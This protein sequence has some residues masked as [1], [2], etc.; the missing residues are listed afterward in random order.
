MSDKN[1]DF[2]DGVNVQG[3]FDFDFDIEEDPSVA[4]DDRS[5]ISKGVG[6]LSEGVVSFLDE[7]GQLQKTIVSGM[8]EAAAVGIGELT[9][10]YSSAT[11]EINEVVRSVKPGLTNIAT[12]IN[13]VLPEGKLKSAVS[14]I[15]RK[16]G[17][18][19]PNRNNSNPVK[20]EQGR[21]MKDTLESIFKVQEKDKTENIVRS[22]VDKKIDRTMSVN[23]HQE[24][25][26]ILD[27]I[28]TSVTGLATYN[29]TI[30]QGYQK[31]SLEL[32]F[33]S[34]FLLKEMVSLTKQ[35]G[36][37]GKSSLDAI[38]KNTGLPDFLKL[39]GPEMMSEHWVRS[40]ID[41]LGQAIYGEGSLL[42]RKMANIK[43]TVMNTL[44]EKAGM[45]DGVEDMA[46]SAA[47]AKDQSAEFA[48]MGLSIDKFE[49]G[50]SMVGGEMMNIAR[51][52]LIKKLRSKYAN[53]DTKLGEFD[54]QVSLLMATAPKRL[55]EF[56]KN[57]GEYKAS[58]N[59]ITGGYRGFMKW[60]RDASKSDIVSMPY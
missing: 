12:D 28:R 39:T 36:S 27:S 38:V 55:D 24:S 44:K 23:Q 25:T 13:K 1:I 26:S 32:N 41:N 40:R 49:M 30:N 42:A 53:D 57:Q 7:P 21:E 31:K 20:E 46:R 48:E 45:I 22:A 33:K 4:S 10:V 6:G 50:G 15:Q 54:A 16:L 18:M 8:P 51:S 52:M 29:S 9:D 60:A 56:L 34:M 58:D 17:L 19:H 47:D 11:S 43:G 2:K 5:P 35:Y 14:A 59:V 3:D 37:H